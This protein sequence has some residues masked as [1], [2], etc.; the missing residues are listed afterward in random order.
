MAALFFRNSL[1][2]DQISRKPH[3]IRSAWRMIVH[4]Y[5]NYMHCVFYGKE[6]EH[7][8]AVVQ[9]KWTEERANELMTTT[10]N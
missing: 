9:Y 2:E 3:D 4:T 5:S 8:M 7:K 6:N 10:R 1:Y